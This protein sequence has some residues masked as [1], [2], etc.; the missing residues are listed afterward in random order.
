[1]SN[2]PMCK[3]ARLQAGALDDELPV[4]EC[5]KCGGAWLRANEYARWLRK[6]KPGTYYLSRIEGRNISLLIQDSNQAALCPDCGHFL[7]RYRIGAR[8][9]FHLDRCNHCNGVWFDRNEWH[10]LK[11][12][13]LH[14]EVN[15]I[16]TQ[17]WQEHIQH[18]DSASRLQA[19]YLARFGGEDY[20]KIQEL[21]AW[22]QDHPRRSMLLAYLADDDPYRA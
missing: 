18:E 8:V 17:P 12:A 22:L 14:D 9:A 1:M 5:Q 16:F 2:C 3:Q 6:Q 13:D 10:A 20:A 4:N 21:R 15:Q 19:M 7:R 11:A